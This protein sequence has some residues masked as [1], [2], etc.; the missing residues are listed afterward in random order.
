MA[1]K[2][3]LL[4]LKIEGTELSQ[5]E[6]EEVAKTLMLGL[7]QKFGSEKVKG[8]VT[9]SGKLKFKAVGEEVDG[10]FS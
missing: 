7:K 4:K 8:T 3:D 9:E 2:S 6:K 5:E 10:W 1:E